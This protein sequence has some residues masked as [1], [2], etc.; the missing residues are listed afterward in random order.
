M[1]EFPFEKCKLSNSDSKGFVYL[2]VSTSPFIVLLLLL[3]FFSIYMFCF[4][5]K[6]FTQNG[7]GNGSDCLLS[8]VVVVFPV[9][10]ANLSLVFVPANTTANH[11]FILL[12]FIAFDFPLKF[13]LFLLAWA[14]SFSRSLCVCVCFSVCLYICERVRVFPHFVGCRFNLVSRLNV[15]TFVS[16]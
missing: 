7:N 6:C 4:L 14:S 1:I 15:A 3:L 13:L 16:I 2:F 9:S 12:H 11:F 5:R 10:L 8:I